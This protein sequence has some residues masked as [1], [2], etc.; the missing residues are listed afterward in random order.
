MHR[1]RYPVWTLR[2]VLPSKSVA[3]RNELPDGRWRD[4]AIARSGRTRIGD[5]RPRRD[6]YEEDGSRFGEAEEHRAHGSGRIPRT[7]GGGD[8]S[9]VRI[10]TTHT[11]SRSGPRTIS[12]SWRSL[13]SV[14]STPRRGPQRGGV[15]DKP[16]RVGEAGTRVPS[17][18]PPG[19]GVLRSPLPHGCVFPR[20]R[21]SPRP[22]RTGLWA[23]P[24]PTVRRARGRRTVGTPPGEGAVLSTG[25]AC[26]CAAAS[27]RCESLTSVDGAPPF[28][29]ERLT[30]EQR[31]TMSGP[32]LRNRDSPCP[33][34]AAEVGSRELGRILQ[35]CRRDG[36]RGGARRSFVCPGTRAHVENGAGADRESRLP[37]WLRNPGLRGPIH[38]FGVSA[39]RIA[40][41]RSCVPKK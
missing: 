12:P 37:R 5:P 20:D 23:G 33:V 4:L 39:I 9:A 28:A 17:L 36:G 22:R 21:D 19:S 40:T 34:P 13:R 8:S 32:P 24:V 27:P 11:E 26:P 14:P 29:H 2:V 25:P 10:Q 38:Y 7:E 1:R 6:R 35:V 3:G 41:G 30:A 31:N 16:G 15:P 18:R